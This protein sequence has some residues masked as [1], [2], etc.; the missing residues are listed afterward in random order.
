VSKLVLRAKV[1]T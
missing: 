1:F